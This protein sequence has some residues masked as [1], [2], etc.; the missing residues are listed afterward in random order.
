MTS[1]RLQEKALHGLIDLKGLHD[2]LSEDRYAH[3]EAN[4]NPVSHCRSKEIGK[5]PSL[6]MAAECIAMSLACK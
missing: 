1:G 3:G 4:S 5:A 2:S 6:E